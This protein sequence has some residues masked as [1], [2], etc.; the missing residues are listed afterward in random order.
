ML[1]SATESYFEGMKTAKEGSLSI[2][3]IVPV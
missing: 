3:L 1:A 2:G